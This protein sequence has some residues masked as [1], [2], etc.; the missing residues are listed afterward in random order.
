MNRPHK[1]DYSGRTVDLLLLKTV[2]RPVSEAVV[3]PNV[4]DGTT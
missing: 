4:A 1:I 3:D 2:A